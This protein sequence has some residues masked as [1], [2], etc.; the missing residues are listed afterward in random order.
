MNNCNRRILVGE[1]RDMEKS[2]DEELEVFQGDGEF[3]FGEED[4][5]GRTPSRPGNP[6]IYQML[7][8]HEQR[9]RG[10]QELRMSNRGPLMVNDGFRG[11]SSRHS[12][13]DSMSESGGINSDCGIMS[14]D[15]D[16][17]HSGSRVTVSTKM[18]FMSLEERKETPQKP[19]GVEGN[20]DASRKRRSYSSKAVGVL[21]KKLR[22]AQ[23][24][25]GLGLDDGMPGIPVSMSPPNANANGGPKYPWA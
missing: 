14:E 13:A 7:S 25:P 21:G 18:D 2:D 15:D 4:L 16:H 3:V 12:D 17:S 20:F 9:E 10:L 1:L 19:G 8:N 11:Y 6:M 22:A 5:S 24:G 23:A